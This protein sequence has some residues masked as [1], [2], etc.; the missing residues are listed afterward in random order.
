[1]IEAWLQYCLAV[2]HYVMYNNRMIFQRRSQALSSSGG[3]TLVG[4]GHVTHK[5][6]IA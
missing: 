4:A 3:K 2:C 6:L 5:K 1:M